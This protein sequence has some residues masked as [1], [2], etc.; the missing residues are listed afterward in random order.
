MGTTLLEQLA[1]IDDHL[2]GLSAQG[3]S[4]LSVEDIDRLLAQRTAPAAVAPSP[5]ALPQAGV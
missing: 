4:P 2:R 1:R 3:M 5:A